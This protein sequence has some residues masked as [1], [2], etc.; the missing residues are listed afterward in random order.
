MTRSARFAF[1]LCLIVGVLSAC[2]GA[3]TVPAAGGAQPMVPTPVMTVDEVLDKMEQ[4][5]LK[6]K[7]FTADVTKVVRTVALETDETY[8]GKVQFVMPRLLKLELTNTETKQEMFYVVGKTYGW[9]C[10]PQKKMARRVALRDIK[11]KA[12]G[13]NPLEYGLARDIHELKKSYTLKVMPDERVGEALARVIELMPIGGEDFAVGR[14]IFW[15]D[16]A[17]W[18][19]AQ[20]RE[21]KS[22]GEIIETHTFA[23]QQVNLEIPP[24]LFE[25]K[26]PDDWDVVVDEEN[27]G[28]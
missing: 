20:V 12:E 15:I 1:A 5:R 16:P 21:Q 10:R 25:F 22:G 24:K 8:T 27:P 6:L 17:T 4:A 26:A 11:E 14:T 13:S 7:S 3:Q 23:R 18:L 19:P 2:A 28:K 9:F